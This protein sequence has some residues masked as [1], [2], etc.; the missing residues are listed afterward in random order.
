MTD[1][2]S[3]AALDDWRKKLDDNCNIEKVVKIIVGNKS[4][5]S[6][7]E[8][9]VDIK[10]GRAYAERRKLEYFETTTVIN[11]GSVTVVF[12]KIA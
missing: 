5:A 7:D 11:D 10:E 3:F 8:R 12:E 1:D 6:K 4:D 2:S 9:R